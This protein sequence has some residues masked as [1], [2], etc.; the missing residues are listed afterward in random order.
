MIK[1]GGEIYRVKKIRTHYFFL[2]VMTGYDLSKRRIPVMEMESSTKGPQVV[3]TACMHGDETGG[4]VVVH[5]LFRI[6][7]RS[8]RCGKVLAFP[9]LNPFGFEITSRRISI[10][11]EDLNRSF[12]GN[13]NG[14]LAQRIA[15][16]VMDNIIKR[17]PDLVL[18][19][20]ND[21]NK[22]IPY[23]IIDNID[24]S[25]V[26][27]NLHRYARISKLPA[28]QESEKISS[29]LSYCLNVSGI[30]SLTFELGESLIINEKNVVYG[31]NAVLNILSVLDMLSHRDDLPGFELPQ[32]VRN[33]ILT[34]SAGP[35]CSRSGILRF[36]K[37][38]GDLVKKGDRLA[39][40]YN[41]FGKLTE[42]ITA[43]QAGIILGHNDY[44]VAYPGSPVMAFGVHDS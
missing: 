4:T 19:L 39:R 43:K 14:S 24:D 42:T 30:P 2:K 22:S 36:S 32:E 28:I 5:E 38:P 35:V 20:H 21:W 12:P 33:S 40:V 11:N 3:L 9:I 6:L 25:V 31:I 44:A 17:K 29:S 18:D 13:I 15:A 41:A 8:L 34:Y 1:T 27:L 7:K 23:T 37:K 16:I 26:L 10:S